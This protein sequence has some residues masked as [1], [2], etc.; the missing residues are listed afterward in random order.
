[1]GWRCVPATR[2]KKG[3]WEGYLDHATCDLDQLER[4]SFEHRNCN[5]KVVPDGSGVWALDVDV[6]GADHEAD[7]VEALQRLVREHGP[8]APRPHGRSGGGGHLLVFKDAGHPIK[9]QSGFPCP[10]MDPRAR[11][12][13]FTVAPSRS[14]SGLYRWVVAP[15]ELEPPVAPDWLLKLVAPPPQ[16]PR[17]ERPTII[18][19][20][21]AQSLLEREVNRVLNAGPG[22]RNSTL[23]EAS[24]TVGG[25]IGGGLLDE[26]EA[27]CALYDAARYIR[28]DDHES[29]AT[30]KS[31]IEGGLKMPLKGAGYG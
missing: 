29:R 23:N 4:W 8:I 21:R 3:L 30:I 16:P 14:G 12:N 24:F 28:L 26:R 27:I 6:P 1:M 17:P 31:G 13:A 7:G 2:S 19:T 18:S 22:K 11:R 15:W 5:W 10:G 25:L 9:C 20:N